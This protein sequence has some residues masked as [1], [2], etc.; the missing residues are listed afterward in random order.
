MEVE[1][2]RGPRRVACQLDQRQRGI[3][4]LAFEPDVV[5]ER[6]QHRAVGVDAGLWDE[7]ERSNAQQ[8]STA[9][10]NRD[11]RHGHAET[12]IHALQMRRRPE[13]GEAY[14]PKRDEDAE[15]VVPG[16]HRG[17]IKDREADPQAGVAV[18]ARL[19]VEAGDGDQQDREVGLRKHAA[20]ER[21]HR[22]G[23]EVRE[24][25]EDETCQQD[26]AALAAL[27]RA[28]SIADDVADGGSA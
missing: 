5:R 27:L 25:G 24:C 9:K 1:A 10:G 3:L 4:E 11:R 23:E 26:L 7:H 16:V 13:A 12:R 17:Q 20:E 15:R 18:A 2:A 22:I 21:A 28:L 14:G 6:D 19:E 8:E